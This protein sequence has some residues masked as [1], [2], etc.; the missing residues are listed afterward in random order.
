VGLLKRL[1]ASKLLFLRSGSA[2]PQAQP[3]D[4][5]LNLRNCGWPTLGYSEVRLAP[6]RHAHEH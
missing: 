4:G 3:R 5:Y 1:A 6:L 2:L